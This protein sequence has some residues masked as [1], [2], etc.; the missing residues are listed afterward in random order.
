M[1]QGR[2][3]KDQPPSKHPL[4]DITEQ[5]RS[6]LPTPR[7]RSNPVR[8]ALASSLPPSSPPSA[9]VPIGAEIYQI[10]P[11]DL[12]SD[13][14]DFE[15]TTA[16]AL[17][18]DSRGSDPFGFLAVE[19]KLKILKAQ[20]QNQGLEKTG[21]NFPSL[22]VPS[23]RRNQRRLNISPIIYNEDVLESDALPSSPSPS[24]PL[25]PK[26]KDRF[27]RNAFA[28][29]AQARNGNMDTVIPALRLRPQRNATKMPR[30]VLTKDDPSI[31]SQDCPPSPKSSASLKES[32]CKKRSGTARK[33]RVTRTTKPQKNSKDEQIEKWD[34]ERRIRLEYFNKLENYQLEKENVYV[35]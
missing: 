32:P 29:D 17:E 30:E 5:K 23:K 22:P 10:L 2:K 18:A 27:P 4:R 14:D 31:S 28:G 9:T 16:R 25:L 3:R 21:K 33:K 7:P 20:K 6:V 34:Q 26:K 1:L 24:N 15:P 12:G 8:A 35:I 19:H 13:F 11:D